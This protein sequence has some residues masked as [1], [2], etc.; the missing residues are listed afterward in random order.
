VWA[1]G[2]GKAATP[3]MANDAIGAIRT[4]VASQCGAQQAAT[5][6]ILYGGSVDATNIAQ[7]MAQVEIDGALVG[8]ASLNLDKFSSIVLQAAAQV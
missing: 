7:L 3:G 8:G 5:A 4:E 2:T 6:R 1:I